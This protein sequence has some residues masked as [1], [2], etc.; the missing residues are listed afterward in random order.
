M[1]SSR[2]PLSARKI[3]KEDDTS[4]FSSGEPSIDTYLK[5]YARQ[6]QRREGPVTY[7]VVDQER[8]VIAYYTIT[9][10][11]LKHDEA[12]RELTKGEGHHSIHMTLL[13]RLGVDEHHQGHGFGRGLVIHAFRTAVDLADLGGS[14]GILVQPISQRLSKYYEQFGFKPLDPSPPPDLTSDPPS[15]VVSPMY[16]RMQSVR[17]TLETF[18]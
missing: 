8:Y 12:P 13:A 10:D 3:E 5:R 9:G 2:T 16:V 6:S 7:V 18:G 11:V 14:K 17:V 15:E 4:R 1:P